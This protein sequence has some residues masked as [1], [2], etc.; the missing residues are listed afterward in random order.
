ML[1]VGKIVCEMPPAKGNPRNS[2]GAFINLTDGRIMFA[3]SHYYSSSAD[4]GA[5][6]AI[7]RCYSSDSGETWSERE[8]FIWPKEHNAQNVMSVSL[9][10]LTSGEIG[11]FYAIK[12]G[13][14]CLL[15]LRRSHDEGK[16]W[17]PATC[18]ITR[19]GYFVTNNDRVIKLKS[20]RL[21]VPASK[22]NWKLPGVNEKRFDDI[23]SVYFY[24][25]DDDG[26]T[27]NES[28]NIS[29]LNSLNTTTGLQEPGVIEL[30][31]GTLWAWAR[32]DMGRQYQTYS[33]DEG[34]SWTSPEP[35]IFTGPCSPLSMKRH[36]Q[37]G[38]LLA[39]WNPIPMYQT[40]KSI[41]AGWGRTPLVG[42]ISNDEG[43]TW[44]HYF[45]V[46]NDEDAGYCYTA[47]HFVD[48]AVLLAYCAGDVNDS[49]SCLVKLRIKKILFSEF[50][51]YTDKLD[52]IEYHR[53]K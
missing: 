5:P 11:L 24:F 26:Y 44:D 9:L 34:L 2:E 17:G 36:P 49:T 35:S 7:A 53:K 43:A 41:A 32:T 37:N 19:A 22:H 14:E 10:R 28:K 21:V 52:G 20:G 50:M 23:G 6:A 40:R 25:S 31:N 15:H 48:D 18:C 45:Y 47:I 16:T 4:D 42:A 33:I 27:W 38:H 29:S 1:K 51:D 12:R 39:I 3:Y 46:D 8:I 30:N 13:D